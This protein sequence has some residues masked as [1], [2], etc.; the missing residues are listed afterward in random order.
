MIRFDDSVEW[1]L[2]TSLLVIGLNFLLL[3][4]TSTP[5]KPVG[6]VNWSKEDSTQLTWY[7]QK[8]R[9]A[10]KRNL[11]SSEVTNR[12][13]VDVIVCV[14]SKLG[15]SLEFNSLFSFT[16]Y[17]HLASAERRTFC[18]CQFHLSLKCLLARCLVSYQIYHMLITDAREESDI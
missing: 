3:K 2:W 13:R 4:S 15:Q 14:W 5:V 6:I 11:L 10:Y 17:C 9:L 8:I 16:N 7:W 12:V 1:Q 18:S